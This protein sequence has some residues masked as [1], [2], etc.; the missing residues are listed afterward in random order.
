[1]EATIALTALQKGTP[2]AVKSVKKPY[3]K[4]YKVFKNDTSVTEVFTDDFK[5]VESTRF[6]IE[7]ALALHSREHPAFHLPDD[8]FMFNGFLSRT[9]AM[10]YAKAG[11]LKYITKLID[12]GEKSYDLLLKYREEH[13]D[14]LNI[15]LTDKNI[16]RLEER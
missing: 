3:Y 13:Y 16:R 8:E 12:D 1:M 7:V 10:R 9:K 2:N 6:K 11:A 4:F 14:D 5:P 15:N